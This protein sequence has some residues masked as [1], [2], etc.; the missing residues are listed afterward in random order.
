MVNYQHLKGWLIGILWIA[1]LFSSIWLINEYAPPIYIKVIIGGLTT[2]LIL[3]LIYLFI[4][5]V[6]FTK[7]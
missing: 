4:K 6:F 3:Y 7:V 1:S 2:I 5:D